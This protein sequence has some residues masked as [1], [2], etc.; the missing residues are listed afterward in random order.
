MFIT[1]VFCALAIVTIY[2]LI[3]VLR[4]I[5][6]LNLLRSNWEYVALTVVFYVAV[7]NLKELGVLYEVWRRLH[8]RQSLYSG[9]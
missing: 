8:V 3:S 5:C 4:Y 7:G 6:T 2:I 9:G 1:S